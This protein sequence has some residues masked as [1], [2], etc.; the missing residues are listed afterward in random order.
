MGAYGGG[1]FVLMGQAGGGFAAPEPLCDRSGAPLRAGM[2]WDKEAKRWHR[3]DEPHGISAT[4]IDFDGDGDLDLLLGTSDGR[5][6][7]RLDEGDAKAPRFATQNVILQAAGK[8]LTVPNRH[9]MPVAAD[10]DADGR[11]D[12]VSGS[13]DGA[14]WWFRNVGEAGKPDFSAP[15]Q[16]VGPGGADAA[17]GVRTQVAIADF[18]GDGA[19]DLLVGDYRAETGTDGKSVKHGHVWLFRR[20][21]RAR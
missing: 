10:W 14:V 13:Y 3:M 18:D 8:D 17:H 11:F 7:L 12:L 9:A 21:G 15:E 20:E 4:P 1:S 16:L 19:L 5:V 2:Y 6:A